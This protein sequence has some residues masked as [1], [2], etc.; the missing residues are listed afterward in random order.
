MTAALRNVALTALLVVASAVTSGMLAPADATA[1][2]PV[3][4]EAQALRGRAQGQIAAAH[5]DDYRSSEAS[6]RLGDEG[7]GG[8]DDQ[9]SRMR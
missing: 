1:M 2:Q 9:P 8:I 3:R 4:V 5:I 6:S 7:A